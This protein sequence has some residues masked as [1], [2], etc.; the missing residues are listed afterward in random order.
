M[1]TG[2]TTADFIANSQGFFAA[3]DILAP[4]PGGMTGEVG[5]NTSTLV[6]TPEPSTWAMMIIGFLGL[7]YAGF[8]KAKSARAIA[9]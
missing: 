8:R 7:G 5:G 2:L 9:A 1:I 6:S 4:K 3:A